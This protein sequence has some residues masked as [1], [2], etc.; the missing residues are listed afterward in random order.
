MVASAVAHVGLMAVLASIDSPPPPPPPRVLPT[1]V[2]VLDRPPPAPIDVALIALPA[3]TGPAAAAPPPPPTA[4][5]PTAPPPPRVPAAPPPRGAAIATTPAGA[6]PAAGGE[7]APATAG[8][9]EAP[10]GGPGGDGPPGTSIFD[11]RRPPAVDLS[12]RAVAERANLGGGAPPPPAIKP[13]GELHPAGGGTYR[14]EQPGFT[15]TVGRNGDVT[16]HDRPSV[17][18]HLPLLDVVPKLPRTIGKKLEGWANDPWKDVREAKRD[19]A[20]PDPI[21]MPGPERPEDEDIDEVIVPLVG[22]TGD[23]TDFVMRQGGLD[24]Y[25]DAKRAWLEKTRAERLELKAADRTREL[26]AAARTVR[27]HLARAWARAELDAAARRAA[28]FELWD[29]AAEDGTAEEQAAGEAVRKEVIGF[30]R[31][32]LPAGGADAFTTAELAAL[33]ARRLSKQ[34]FEPY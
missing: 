18:F 20:D 12:P 31:A 23:I 15:V 3:P 25:A 11:M 16:F 28:I 33:N 29:D 7:L 6:T 27:K 13:S 9:G 17:E 5:P 30:V 34:R 26:A 14:S 21:A 10:V 32:H 8:G 19:P 22:A 24:P 2:T 4:P 1:T